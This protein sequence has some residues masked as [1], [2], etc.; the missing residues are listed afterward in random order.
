MQRSKLRDLD[1]PVR[2]AFAGALAVLLMGW[3]VSL[4]L[5]ARQVD[6]GLGEA[7]S[8]EATRLRAC[9]PPLERAIET[10]MRRHI[11][12][13]GER[14]VLA[15]WMRQGAKMTSYYGEPSRVLARR[16][17]SCHGASAQGGIRLQTYGDAASLARRGGRDPYGR[18]G[19]LHVHL[20]A[21][22]A[23]LALLLLALVHTRLP[24]WLA[25]AVGLVPLAAHLLSA[26]LA[27]WGCSLGAGPYLLWLCEVL[28]IGTWPICSALLLWD[29]F[30][31]ARD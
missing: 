6:G 29:L 27:I 31:P 17:A 21:I 26:V 18:R 20:F 24:R 23:V 8:P 4:G 2:I 7:L 3:V 10:T 25:L 11:P 13:P 30:A 22:G 14:R 15:G 1:L 16:C 9:A 28:V 19:K 12:D 5:G